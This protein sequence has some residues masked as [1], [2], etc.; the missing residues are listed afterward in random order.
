METPAQAVRERNCGIDA[1]RIVC[2]LMVT[3]L[4]VL[5]AGGV[6]EAVDA[7]A[8]GAPTVHRATAYFLECGALCAVNC[9]ALISGYV[10]MGT[11]YKFTNMAVLWLRVVFYTV[12]ITVIYRL[13]G[14]AAIDRETWMNAFF[15]VMRSYYWYFTAYAGLYLFMPFLS[16][17]FERMKKRQ[18]QAL[19]ICFLICFS[20]LPTLFGRDPFYAIG[21]YS[22]IWLMILYIAGRYIGKYGLFHRVRTGRLLGG[23]L[24]MTALTCACVVYAPTGIM[25]GGNAVFIYLAHGRW[26]ERFSAAGLCENT[27]VGGNE[28]ARQ[29]FCAAVL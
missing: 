27:C 10:G 14:D 13:M 23:Y 25:G 6:L 21:G 22:M 7:A 28:Q 1:L 12:G 19:M 29:V 11:K 15:P 2:M 8:A 16:I 18:V 9:Y 17:G 26:G 3:L 24:I 4:H 20:I 5:G